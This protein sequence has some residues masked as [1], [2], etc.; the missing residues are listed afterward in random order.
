MLSIHT[1]DLIRETEEGRYDAILHCCNCFNTL[2][3][4]KAKGIA[5][6]IGEYWPIARYLD[7]TTTPGDLNKL[8]TFTHGVLPNGTIIFNV[9]GQYGYGPGGQ[10]AD[11]VLRGIYRTPKEQLAWDRNACHV[12]YE[13]VRKAF[14]LINEIYPSLKIG[15]PAFGAGLAYGDLD[16]IKSIINDTLTNHEVYMVLWDKE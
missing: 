6:T 7:Q 1:G 11:D 5:K 12:H 4:G 2:A 3:K 9:Y 13:S 10:R 8:G 16:I 15:M 14:T